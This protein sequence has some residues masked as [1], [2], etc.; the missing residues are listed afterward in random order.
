[1]PLPL[2]GEQLVALIKKNGYCVP[3]NLGSTDQTPGRAPDPGNT[4]PN[5]ENTTPDPRRAPPRLRGLFAPSSF[6]SLLL[7]MLIVNVP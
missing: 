2:Q 5:P 1:M 3:Q 7:C 4:G 6:K